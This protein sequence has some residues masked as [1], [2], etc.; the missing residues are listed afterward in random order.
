MPAPVSVRRRL[1]PA[2]AAVLA[3][4]V[5]IAVGAGPLSDVGTGT[6]QLAAR[7]GGETITDATARRA[8]DAGD[9]LAVAAAPGLYD[10]AL[11]D[12][13]VALVVMPGADPEVVDGLRRQADAAGADVTATWEIGDALLASGGTALVDSLGRRL[14]AQQPN[15]PVDADAPAYE[16]LGGLLG[17][18]VASTRPTGQEPVPATRTVAESLRTA[19]LVD[20]PTEPRRRA[21]LVLVVLGSEPPADAELEAAGDAVAS[22]L[23]SGLGERSVATVVAGSTASGA[24]GS[25]QRL[26]ATGSAGDRGWSSVDGA[27]RASGRVLAALALVQGVD[28]VAGDWGTSGADGALPRAPR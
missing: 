6:E 8:L 9:E 13:G 18:A 5:G 10:D 14:L 12:T 17:V 1:A 20:G 22:G 28:G 27:E 3:L 19:D 7:T 4:A 26:R 21:P 23:L 15:L 24:E 2:A 11:A 25:L 16:R